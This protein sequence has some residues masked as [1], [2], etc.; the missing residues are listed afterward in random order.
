MSGSRKMWMIIN[1]IRLFMWV[2]C[3]VIK[4]INLFVS[5]DILPITQSNSYFSLT[6]FKYL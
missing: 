2:R 3:K 1:Y 4:L 5:Y 6:I